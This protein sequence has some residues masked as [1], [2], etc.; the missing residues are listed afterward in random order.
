MKRHSK[1]ATLIARIRGPG[2]TAAVARGT[3]GVLTVNGSA[4]LVGLAIRLFLAA[5]MGADQYGVFVYALS[6]ASLFVIVGQFGFG[7]VLTRFVATYRARREFRLLNGVLR[8]SSWLVF[9]ISVFAGTILTGFALLSSGRLDAEL[10]RTLALGGLLVPLASLVGLMNGGLRGLRRVVLGRL[11][12]AIVPRVMVGVALLTAFLAGVNLNAVSVMTL[13]LVATATALAVAAGTLRWYLPPELKNEGSEYRIREWLGVAAPLSL[14]GGMNVMLARVDVLMVGVLLG[15]NA[16]GTYHLASRLASVTAFGLTAS[17]ATVAPRIAALY[18]KRSGELQRLVTMASRGAGA[19]AFCT[20][21]VLA[22]GGGALLSLFGASFSMGRG[23]LIVLATGHVLAATF[24]SAGVLLTMTGHH[25]RAARTQALALLV[26]VVGNALL[27]LWWG[28]IGAA[29]A[30][31]ASQALMRWGMYWGAKRSTG[32][33]S[34]AF[35]HGLLTNPLT[36]LRSLLVGI[37][38]SL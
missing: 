18:T 27:I 21:V 33:S 36:R 37:K 2:S 30:T 9:A 28:I 12:E 10:V 19:F 6:W 11:N 26:N 8:S 17:N 25:R 1:T 35:H 20:W 34:N 4:E 3:A 14:M 22:L 24:G 23:A 29:C 32:I 16:A 5:V 38:N 13:H 15:T 7:G 31:V